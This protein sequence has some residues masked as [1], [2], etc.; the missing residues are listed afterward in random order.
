MLSTMLAAGQI[1]SMG[2]LTVENDI[3]LN[4]NFTLIAS[5]TESAGDNIQISGSM[6]NTVHNIHLQAGDHIYIDA[7][8]D[9]QSVSL[10]ADHEGET[11]VDADRGSIVNNA[12]VTSSA[13]NIT[14]FESVSFTG[15]VEELSA[16]VVNGDFT[17]TGTGSVAIGSISAS[18]TVNITSESGAIIDST[19]DDLIDITS[20]TGNIILSAAQG[21]SGKVNTSLELAADSTVNISATDNIVLHALGNIN[22]ANIV[23]SAGNI[24]IISDGS[25]SG[26]T[27]SADTRISLQAQ[28]RISSFTSEFSS[29]EAILMAGSGIGTADA[30]FGT[31]IER[32]DL[33]TQSGDIFVTNTNA[34]TIQDLNSDSNAIETTA[35]VRIEAAS[36]T[37]SQDIHAGN[38]LI[39]KTGTSEAETNT[40]TINANI[41]LN[42]NGSIQFQAGDDIT[43]NNSQIQASDIQFIADHE[44]D[45]SGGITQTDGSIIAQNLNLEAFHTL[46]INSELNEI[47]NLSANVSDGDF[48]FTGASSIQIDQI[49]ANTVTLK[50][51]GAIIDTDDETDI[52]SEIITLEAQ[53]INLDISAGTLTAIAQST[54]DITAAGALNANKVESTSGPINILA[55]G[56]I[57]AQQVTGSNIN[58]TNTNGDIEIGQMT[59]D[60]RVT[61]S[62]K[63]A[64]HSINRSND[65]TIGNLKSRQW[66]GNIR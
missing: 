57:T 22:L 62:A 13:L 5:D 27:I 46:S 6:T 47:S 40:L 34:L 53:E 12:V 19:D 35:I 25:I 64:I 58:L 41:T 16:S 2:A 51:T 1:T 36:I 61:V 50:S 56:T 21:I 14:S 31:D 43:L 39:L 32:I 23:S 15:N 26:D 4:G 8:I 37:V 38:Q 45:N 65:R 54:I 9:S 49:E 52:H 59:A 60:N 66:Y 63:N 3:L 33:Q 11:V 48:I 55:D 24:Q 20:G 44:K 28:D 30:I 29:T 10:L 7:P 18:G 42:E 17:Y